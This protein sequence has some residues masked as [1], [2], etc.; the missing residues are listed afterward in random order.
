MESKLDGRTRSELRRGS[1]FK[2]TIRLSRNGKP[3]GIAGPS[4]AQ[5]NLLQKIQE[6]LIFFHFLAMKIT[7]QMPLTKEKYISPD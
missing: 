1:G 6:N 2:T 4:R 5:G 7:T 3:F